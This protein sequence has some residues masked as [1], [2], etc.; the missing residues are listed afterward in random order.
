MA[1]KIGYLAGSKT[2]AEVIAGHTFIIW[3]GLIFDQSSPAGRTLDED[4]A[5]YRTS[6]SCITYLMR[7]PAPAR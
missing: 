4:R 2:Y 1:H 3:D 5:K 7:R 6:A